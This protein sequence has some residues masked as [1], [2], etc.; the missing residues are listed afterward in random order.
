MFVGAHSNLHEYT[1]RNCYALFANNFVKIFIPEEEVLNENRNAVEKDDLELDLGR[2]WKI[3]KRS[4][5]YCV[6]VALLVAIAAAV[7]TQT[8]IDS[9]YTATCSMYVYSN[10]DR[11][12]TDSSVASS[13]LEASQQLVETYIVVLE[14]NTV[15]DAVIESLDLDMSASSLRSM[16][17][18][19]QEGDTEI[20][21]VSVTS[22]DPTEAANIANAIADIAPDEIVRVVKAGGV[23]II[24]YATVPTGRSY[25]SISTNIM[26][27][28]IG[29]FV[30]SFALFLIRDLTDTTIKTEADIS[31]FNINVLGS[32]PKIS[33]RT[34]RKEGYG[35]A[36]E[37]ETLEDSNTKKKKTE[38]TKLRKGGK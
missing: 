24:D 5:I 6:I 12:S 17:S 27:G 19:S 20:F 38:K 37:E 31:G 28:F 10:T 34:R 22:T 35:A 4:I 33:T 30:V 3:L 29:G 15:L 21:N 13:E 8:M 36:S 11:V 9:Q 2:L 1:V 14:S 18:C 23:E 26:Y 25:P 16:L 7:F 32:V